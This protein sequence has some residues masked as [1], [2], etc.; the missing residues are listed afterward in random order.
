[1]CNA[2]I[3][4]IPQLFA[5]FIVWLLPCLCK[6][7]LYYKANLVVQLQTCRSKKGGYTTGD[8]VRE[9]NTRQTFYTF[10]GLLETQKGNVT[11]ALADD[12][13]LYTQ[14]LANDMST[15]GQVPCKY[16]KGFFGTE[17]PKYRSDRTETQ[18]VDSNMFYIILLW[19]LNDYRPNTVNT[20]YLSAQRAFR[21]LENRIENDIFKEPIDA[22]WETTR[23]HD[24]YLLLTNVLMIKTIRSMEMISLVNS[25]NRIQEKCRI[26]HLSLIHI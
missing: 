21:F 22:S 14:R 4:A 16:V 15:K 12:I 5:R 25:D 20:L 11:K 6:H 10:L 26:L 1:M 7:K 3:L 2:Y 23:L 19:L 17:I 9:I 24:G 8:G 13:E 18:V